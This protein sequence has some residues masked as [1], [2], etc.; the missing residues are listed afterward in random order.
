MF[1]NHDPSALFSSLS[2]L[3]V[4][5][6]NLMHRAK[7][8]RA[9]WH[10][11]QEFDRVKGTR[12]VN[13]NELD[14]LF[15]NSQNLLDAQPQED[16]PEQLVTENICFHGGNYTVYPDNVG[17]GAYVTTQLLR[18]VFNSPS[19]ILPDEFIGSVYD[20]VKALLVISDSVAN[21][22]GHGRWEANENYAI[23]QIK[24]PGESM[25]ETLR[26]GVSFNRDEFYS[27]LSLRDIPRTAIEPFTLHADAIDKAEIEK[28]QWYT[29]QKP[30]LEI[31]D[32]FIVLAPHEFTSTIRHFI[33]NSAIRANMREKL[34][35]AYHQAVIA[36]VRESSMLMSFKPIPM[37][38]LEPEPDRKYTEVLFHIDIEIACYVQVVTDFAENYSITDPWTSWDANSVLDQV[39]NRLE[40][41]VKH[42]SGNASPYRKILNILVIGHFGRM[43][44]AGFKAPPKGC[45]QIVLFAEDLET[46]TRM[47]DMDQ[48]TLWKFAR[49]WAEFTKSVKISPGASTLDIYSLYKGHGESFYISDDQKPNLL[50]ILPDVG[51]ELRIKSKRSWDKHLVEG[52]QKPTKLVEVVRRHEDSD[53]VPIY[54]PIGEF[55]AK[56]YEQVIEG[57]VYPIWVGPNIDYKTQELSGTAF[58]LVETFAFWVWQLLPTLQQKVI[59]SEPIRISFRL[60]NPSTWDGNN[61]PDELRNGSSEFQAEVVDN[62]IILTLPDVFL[63]FSSGQSNEAER[64]LIRNI[65]HGINKYCDEEKIAASETDQIVESIAP[66]GLKRKF[67]GI[68]TSQDIRLEMRHL[69]P[70]RKLSEHNMMSQLDGL[71][72]EVVNITGKTLVVG[73]V[74]DQDRREINEAILTIHLDRMRSKIKQ[75]DYQQLLEKAI[76][77][78]EGTVWKQQFA[79]YT[80]PRSAACFHGT[81]KQAKLEAE[82]TSEIANLALSARFL[83]EFLVAEPHTASSPISDD[84]FDELLAIAYHYINWGAM[85]DEIRCR[86]FSH[87]LSI[88]ES[89]RIGNDL[90]RKDMLDGFL[91]AKTLEDLETAQEDNSYDLGKE[92]N[93]EH[94]REKEKPQIELPPDLSAAIAAE[95]GCSLEELFSVFIS[96]S[97]AAFAIY[98]SSCPSEEYEALISLIS[99]KSEVAEERVRYIIEEFSFRPRGRWDH[100]PTGFEMDDILPYRYNRRLSMIRRPFLMIHP[101]DDPEKWVVYWGPRHLDNSIKYLYHLIEN[102]Q[103]K[104]KHAKS[105]ELQSY[106]GAMNDQ[107]GKDF[108]NRAYTWCNQHLGIRV[109]RNLPIAPGKFFDSPKEL[110]DI[111]VLLVDPNEM[112]LF[113]VECKRLNP[114]RNAVE[115]G[116]EIDMLF[117]RDPRYPDREVRIDKHKARIAWLKDNWDQVRQKLNL[118]EGTWK[119]VPLFLTSLVI[120]SSFVINTGYPVI[121]LR[122][123]MRNGMDA[124]ATISSGAH[125]ETVP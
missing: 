84:D 39:R 22:L 2:G 70:Y 110:G 52:W 25:L 125:I 23:D 50:N 44:V 46:M 36:S 97:I 114:S 10:L 51:R 87:K 43:L 20:P 115:I 69:P 24:I 1:K 37:E 75:Y 30:L 48:L 68:D 76:L 16:I 12:V 89:G 66:V 121:T 112:L 73:D 60:E 107:L 55:F 91:D 109:E 35:Y 116:S 31:G 64:L 88:L 54:L 49:G 72:D 102:G 79:K 120:P 47:R 122:T 63:Y 71:V 11:L 21:K 65:I 98:D 100:I 113:C 104:Q 18:A 56:N 57:C 111:D 119:I 67:N 81:A 59:L 95:F 108:E 117:R 19:K 78:N 105:Q 7:I 41:V 82:H 61:R 14:S 96:M 33:L 26:N 32:D 94:E 6:D 17:P 93:S 62:E 42:L 90:N 123:L 86:V 15:S 106:I 99:E 5:P 92:E 40:I 13:K 77:V 3:L 4:D 118:S 34:A 103:F 74:A 124:L 27:L 9:I 29:L 28:D 45:E 38:G 53:E 85:G 83:I 80:A 58:H 8:G 101:K